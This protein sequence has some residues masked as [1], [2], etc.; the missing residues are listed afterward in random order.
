MI[1]E[2]VGLTLG[3][4]APLH[5]SHQHLIE[6]ALAET[7]RLVVLI[8]DCPEVIAVPLGV[9]AA[10]IRRLYPQVEVIEAVDGPQQVGSAPEITRAHDAY[11]LRVPS[12]GI[13][14]RQAC[15][16]IWCATSSF[17]ARRR[18][19]RPRSV[20]GW[21]AGTARSGWPAIAIA[22]RFCLLAVLRRRAIVRG[23][24]RAGTGTRGGGRSSQA[25]I[26]SRIPTSR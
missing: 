7:E 26:E 12:I 17:S 21:P 23:H 14:W 1:N 11:I 22:R 19:A 24:I 10:W 6:T 9:R 8:Y 16:A 20:N 5:R 4:F 18:R 25:R 3:K 15:T 13:G 2:R